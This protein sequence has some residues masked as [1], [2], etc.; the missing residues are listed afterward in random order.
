MPEG[1]NPPRFGTEPK[2]VERSLRKDRK[3]RRLTQPA[4]P[5]SGCRQGRAG[6]S[7]LALPPFDNST[8]HGNAD[9][10]PGHEAREQES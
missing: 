10:L 6:R 9:S 1:V 8:V 2:I 7:A 5:M 4:I 3:S